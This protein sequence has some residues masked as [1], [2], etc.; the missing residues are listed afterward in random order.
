MYGRLYTL[1]ISHFVGCFRWN[2]TQNT[3]HSLYIFR[4]LCKFCVLLMPRKNKPQN[5]S[6]F[7]ANATLA[8]NA[9][10]YEKRKKGHETPKSDAKYPSAHFLFFA[11]C[12]HFRVFCDKCIAGLWNKV[13]K[14]E[15][16]VLR[17]QRVKETWESVFAMA[18]VL[19]RQWV[20][21]RLSTHDLTSG[22]F[23]LGIFRLKFFSLSNFFAHL[24]HFINTKCVQN[25]E[26]EKLI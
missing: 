6:T 9:A 1:C 8:P 24:A 18:S 5:P 26:V 7:R 17:P 4:I 11:F 13:P 12:E 16:P 20:S 23:G 22:Q 14:H 3:K 10:K 21:L 15:K 25:F 19:T 2:T